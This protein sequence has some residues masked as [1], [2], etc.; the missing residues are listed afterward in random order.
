M[1]QGLRVRQ[2]FRRLLGSRGVWAVA[3]QAL[4]SVSNFLVNV[5][6]ARW[7]DEAAYGMFALGFAALL[8]VNAVQTPLLTEPILVFSAGRFK[9][10]VSSYQQIALRLNWILGAVVGLIF[11]GI[12]VIYWISQPQSAAMYLGLAISTPLV[13]YSWIT[14]RICYANLV[15]SVSAKAGALYM[16]VFLGTALIFHKAGWLQPLS[17]FA[18]MGLASLVAGL[19][20][21]K[22]LYARPQTPTPDLSK[23]VLAQHWN[24]GRWSLLA[25][26]LYWV[27]TN[28]P[29]VLLARAGGLEDS[30]S[31]RALLNAV[32]PVASLITALG[33]LLIPSFS[34]TQTPQQLLQLAVKYIG[35]FSFISLA[36]WLILGAFHSQIF[37]L[38]YDDTYLGISGLLWFLGLQPLFQGI[39][40]VFQSILR[41]NEKPQWIVVLYGISTL[42]MTTFGSWL[43]LNYQLK[44]AVLAMVMVQ[45]LL[46]LAS[47]WVCL[48]V[49]PFKENYEPKP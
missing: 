25:S 46:M 30:A 1:L 16:L 37:S 23:E 49:T 17:A 39:T 19:W 41:A 31:L 14:R 26:F 34:R 11:I 2:T 20:I 32:L 29:L 24:Y 4:Y 47:V 43:I 8:L 15:P 45:A 12:A 38:L 3:D 10:S 40:T 28:L 42:A 27:P 18:L 44:G 21:Q 5:L 35:L 13:L 7:M 48:R 9:N 6:L 33:S 36:S 22:T